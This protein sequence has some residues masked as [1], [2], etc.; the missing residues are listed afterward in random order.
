MKKL[1]VPAALLLIAWLA[2]A[3]TTPN[4]N[5]QA[6]VSSASSS[7]VLP[8]LQLRG[9]APTMF[10]TLVKE[11]GFSG[12][13]AASNRGCLQPPEE[14]VSIAAGT[15]FE[16]A[17]AIVARFGS[18]S[19]WNVRR[20][21][22]LFLP[23]GYVPPL[24]EVQIQSFTWDKNMPLREVL[25]RIRQLPQ[26]T[27]AAAKLGLSEAPFEGG[28]TRVCIRNCRE[29][30]SPQMVVETERN[31]QLLAVLNRVAQAHKAVWDYSEFRCER[32]T[33]FSFG[34]LAEWGGKAS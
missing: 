9:S 17:V 34:V 31:V 14:A 21:V 33:L 23:D 32:G 10:A 24:L 4:A 7:V 13:V 28:A 5:E 2:G 18:R 22:A 15:N 27:E 11:A 16:N 25:A 26:V 29:E 3:Q 30:V 19:K 8:E 6:S 12:G 20:G 1:I